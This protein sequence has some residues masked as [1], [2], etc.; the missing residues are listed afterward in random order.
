MIKKVLEF[1]AVLYVAAFR[2]MFRENNSPLNQGC[3]VVN[4]GII[5]FW[6]VYFALK[7]LT[8]WELNIIALAVLAWLALFIMTISNITDAIETRKYTRELREVRD[9]M[10]QIRKLLD[11]E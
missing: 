2:A 1:P 11:K 5:N 7:P 10:D 3:A 4:F 9:R 6:L 8:G